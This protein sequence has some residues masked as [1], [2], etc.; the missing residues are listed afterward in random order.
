MELEVQDQVKN[1][2]IIEILNNL[3]FKKNKIKKFCYKI[4]HNF[5]FGLFLINIC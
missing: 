4:L 2:I 1:Y 5:L 3:K